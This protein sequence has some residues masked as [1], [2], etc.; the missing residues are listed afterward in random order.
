MDE[1]IQH[2]AT[3][4]TMTFADF[5][6]EALYHSRLG[7]YEKPRTRVGKTS[8]SDYFTAE[9]IGPVFANLVVE[10]AKN[11][12]GG[13]AARRATFVEIGAE[14]EGA[15]VFSYARPVF[16]EAFAARRG[17]ALPK[18]APLVVFSNELFDAQPFHRV[19]RSGGEWRE[20]GVRIECGRAVEVLLNE[21]SAPV[22]TMEP[23]FPREAADGR[24]I[25]LPLEAIELMDAIAANE[26]VIALVAF[27]YGL[28]WDDLLLRRPCGT[29]RSY[30]GQ[31]LCDEVLAD[32]GDQDITCHVAWDGLEAVLRNRGFSNVKTER[33]EAF[34]I[35][36]SMP[37]VEK[38]LKTGDPVESGRLRELLHPMRMGEIF[39]VLSAKRG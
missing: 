38:I 24:R 37:C 5:M 29:A 19:I 32:P 33:Q 11:L 8:S 36:N 4:G 25:D 6:R 2:L 3:L 16:A 39:Q 14:P 22:K 34:F 20:C 17:D 13:D 7:Y 18:N 12:V 15:N 9:A 27:D 26:N 1:L 30:R 10:A 21:S 23:R 35:N 28:D 31:K